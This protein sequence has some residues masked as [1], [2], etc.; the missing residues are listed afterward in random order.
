MNIVPQ[1]PTLQYRVQSALERAV[2]DGKERGVQVSVYVHGELVA[3]AWAGVAN[4]LTGDRV[5]AGTL[6]PVWS[7]SKGIASTVIHLLAERGLLSYDMRLCEVWPEFGHAGKES[8]TLGHALMHTAG[9]AALPDGL[10]F[11]DMLDWDTACAA[12]AASSP[13]T[14]PGT[15][16]AYHAKTFGWLIGETARRVDG[17]RFSDLVW[18]EIAQPLGLDTLHIGLR[19]REGVPHAVAYLEDEAY[20][21]LPPPNRAEI[22]KMEAAKVPQPHQMNNP[23]MWS[24]C[25]PSSNGLMNARAIAKH[26]ASLLPGGVDGISLLPAGRVA[27]ATQWET[28]NDTEGVAV[29]RGLGYQ[30]LD[31]PKCDG[32]P[33][34]G[35]GHGGYG[36]SMG[37]AFPE[38]GLAIGYTRN[39]LSAQNS[40]DNL[41]SLVGVTISRNKT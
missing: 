12:L 39:F 22:A 26:Y 23:D 20:G 31:G 2:S 38:L 17:R 21:F 28:R 13:S 25:L 14:P 27:A 1:S 10:T 4:S 35:L 29:T 15:Q 24:A 34:L 36:G 33:T 5:S 3:D 41:L 18:E 37:A 11:A 19:Q 9:L 32:V 40:W 30:Q 8:I 6:F 7:V 16:F